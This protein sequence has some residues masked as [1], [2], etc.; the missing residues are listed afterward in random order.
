M[1]RLGTA[2]DPGPDPDP[3][4]VFHRFGKRYSIV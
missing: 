3:E 4:T 2:E 1:E